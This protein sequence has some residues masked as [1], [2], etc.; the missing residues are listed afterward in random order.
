M[1]FFTLLIQF[2]V[3]QN[4]LTTTNISTVDIELEDEYIQ[5]GEKY[6]K[7]PYLIYPDKNTEMSVLWQTHE[8]VDCRIQWGQTLDVLIGDSSV[9]EYG[10]DHQYKVIIKNLLPAVHYVYRVVADGDTAGGNFYTGKEN[11]DNHI[12]FYAYGDT[13][14]YPEDHD[15]VAAQI[16]KNVEA[17]PGGQ[18]FI[19]SNGDLVGRTPEENDEW[20]PNE[21]K[22]DTQFF[23]PQYKNIVHMIATLPYMASMGNY[24]SAEEGELFRKYFPYTIYETE[25]FYYSFDNGPVHFTIVD[26]YT[27]Y[28]VG[29][30]QYN[31]IKNDL[32]SST[33]KWKIFLLHAPGWSGGGSHGNDHDVQEILQPLAVENG[34]QFFFAG[35]NHY[36]AR[37]V[38]NGVVHITTGGGGAPLYDPASPPFPKIVKLDKSHHFCKIEIN[39]DELVFSAIR[40]DGSLIEQFAFSDIEIEPRY[41]I[42]V[43]TIG[44]GT[45]KIMPAQAD[46][47]KNEM[48]ILN[49]IPDS[50]SEFIGWSGDEVGN[51]SYLYILMD[52]S[53]NITATFIGI[54]GINQHQ[55]TSAKLNVFP[56]PASTNL[57]ITYH[58]NKFSNVN[59]SVIDINGKEIAV[60]LSQDESAG[61]KKI[62]WDGRNS[63]GNKLN[64]MYFVRLK[65]DNEEAESFK[66]LMK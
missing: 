64:G 40:K 4:S 28:S 39:D 43:D 24:E 35:H 1:F 16:L 59:I 45:V 29:S 26:Q 12:T 46:Y 13:R 62:H 33:K 50:L 30:E 41:N 27:D 60:L 25:R 5:G 48:V 2:S 61:T 6:R 14:T 8:T 20:E 18:T 58:L 7:G 19:I 22:W 15:A 34:V 42:T 17:T 63:R 55:K 38:V 11:A 57:T 37:A 21:E 65:L 10:D 52:T 44:F 56:N 51:E 31:W 32:E 49:A 9:S 47:E 36:Y 23:D 54:D 53:K 3:S 66:I